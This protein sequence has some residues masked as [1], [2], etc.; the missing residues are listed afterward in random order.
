MGEVANDEFL[1]GVETKMKIKEMYLEKERLEK[2]GNALESKRKKFESEIMSIQNGI[3]GLLDKSSRA[4]NDNEKAEYVRIKSKERIIGRAIER[5][6]DKLDKLSGKIYVIEKL[7]ERVDEENLE[8]IAQMPDLLGN[9]SFIWTDNRSTGSTHLVDIKCDREKGI[10]AAIIE[11]HNWSEGHGIGMYSELYVYA[12]AEMNRICRQGFR[13]AYRSENDRWCNQL[14]KINS[15][16][17]EGQKIKL[18]VLNG[19]GKEDCF[20]L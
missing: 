13:D 17:I 15:M 19:E 12:N 8:A 3:V 11:D 6:Y 1:M 18:V 2:L 9:L 20:L 4:A 16:K 10:A 14:K 5:T 7:G